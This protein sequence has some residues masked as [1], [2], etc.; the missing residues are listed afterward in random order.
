VLGQ[1]VPCDLVGLAEGDMSV[2]DG[3]QQKGTSG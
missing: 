3:L 2:W 1:V